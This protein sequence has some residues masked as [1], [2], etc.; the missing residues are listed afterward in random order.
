[1]GASGQAIE[2]VKKVALDY[3]EG[4][5]TGDA[6][7]VGRAF[8]PDLCKRYIKDNE[9]TQLSYETMLEYTRS[10]RG[11]NAGKETKKLEVEVLDIRENIASVIIKSKFIDYLQM[12][13]INNRWYI[14]NILWDFN[15]DNV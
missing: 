12:A 10:G 9:I 2:E 7:R 11:V 6:E 3:M 8:H 13:V 15:K 4:Y 1:M 5:F 14:I